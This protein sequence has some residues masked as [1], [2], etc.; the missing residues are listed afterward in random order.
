MIA[1][2]TAVLMTAMIIGVVGI[3]VAASPAEAG[4]INTSRSNIKAMNIV[5]QEG[6]VACTNQAQGQGGQQSIPNTEQNAAGEELQSDPTPGLEFLTSVE[7]ISSEGDLAVDA[8][9]SNDCS[10]EQNLDADQN[11]ESGDDFSTNEWDG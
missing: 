2:K 10:L 4:P 8:D 6:D 11:A 1:T 7:G 3:I 5:Q 9:Q